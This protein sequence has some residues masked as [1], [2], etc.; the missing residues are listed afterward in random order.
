MLVRAVTRA[1]TNPDGPRRRRRR[2]EGDH[3]ADDADAAAPP[4]DAEGPVDFTD[5]VHQRE[6][7]VRRRLS[8]A[9]PD[10]AAQFCQLEAMTTHG[11]AWREALRVAS[12]QQSDLI[13][14]G[15]AKQFCSRAIP[16]R[17]ND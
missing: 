1:W 12:R 16:R 6:A 2:K 8:D 15:G 7:A 5:V 17:I 9:I 3:E 11:Q 10:T 14:M 13:V 4:D